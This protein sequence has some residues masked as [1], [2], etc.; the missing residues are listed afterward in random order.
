[1][2]SGCRVSDLGFS[3][4]GLGMLA[5]SQSIFDSLT[6][7]IS[8]YSSMGKLQVSFAKEPYKRDYILP[9]SH[10][11]H[12]LFLTPLQKASKNTESATAPKPSLLEGSPKQTDID[13]KTSEDRESATAPKPFCLNPNASTRISEP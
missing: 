12:C 8:T 5:Q 6:P 1:M 2:S 7:Q 4:H 10:Q 9:Y 3:L 13:K 11:Y